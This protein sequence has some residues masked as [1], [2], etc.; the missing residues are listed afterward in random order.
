MMKLFFKTNAIL[1]LV[2]FSLFCYNCKSINTNFDID[3]KKGEFLQ[4]DLIR[5]LFKNNNKNLIE[6]NETSS[7]GIKNKMLKINASS[8]GF[9]PDD[10]TTI[11]QT[12]FDSGASFILIPAMNKPWI[13]KPLF[14]RSNTTIFIEEGAQ[15]IA[16]KGEFKGTSDSLINLIDLENVTIF[17]Y[18]S[19]IEMLK[20]DY[21]ND[22]Y[23]RGE[24]RH[25]ININGCSNI[26]IYGITAESSGGDGIYIGSGKQNYSANI[27]VENVVLNNHHRQGIS[28]ISAQDLTINNVRISDT[29]GT[30]PSAGIDFEP[31]LPDE[32][33]INC[34][35][36]NSIIS[37]NSGPGIL[38]YLSSQNRTTPPFSIQIKSCSILKNFF[39]LVLI[40]DQKGLKGELQLINND[41]SGISLI[42]QTNQDIQIINN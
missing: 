28:V 3:R 2:I 11:L 32:R 37:N 18:G 9:D 36:T 1:L 27:R 41:L 21:Q 13:V 6:S 38:I 29:H 39:S 31:N 12:A 19:I 33:L 16:K 8:F 4:K 25:T 40:S 24:W 20:K 34:K 5:T 17:G 7:A 42:P 35:V 14:L 30:S 26:G 10:S 15:I 23:K 22:P